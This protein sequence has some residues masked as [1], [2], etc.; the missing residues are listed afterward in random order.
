MV[1]QQLWLNNRNGVRVL[2]INDI[3]EVFFYRLTASR[4]EFLSGPFG[5]GEGRL[6]QME[7]VLKPSCFSLSIKSYSHK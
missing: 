4:E 5:I 3:N 6:F 1:E 7:K 2:D